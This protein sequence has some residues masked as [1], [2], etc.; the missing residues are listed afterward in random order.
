MRSNL[1]YSKK[2]NSPFSILN[3]KL[4]HRWTSLLLVY[5]FGNKFEPFINIFFMLNKRNCMNSCAYK[6]N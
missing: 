5:A 2:F 3:L 1:P 6:A 4:S